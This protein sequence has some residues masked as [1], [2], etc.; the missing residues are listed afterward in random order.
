MK[1]PS[2]VVV[3]SVIELALLVANGV[4][5][6]ISVFKKKP[7]KKVDTMQPD[8]TVTVTEEKI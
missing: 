8:C 6:V 1:I 5:S 7:K 2:V 3:T 4:K